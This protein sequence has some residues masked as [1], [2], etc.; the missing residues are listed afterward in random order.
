[1]QGTWIL[2]WGPNWRNDFLSVWVSLWRMSARPPSPIGGLL[3]VWFLWWWTR[4]EKCLVS[5]GEFGLIEV[6][7]SEKPFGDNPIKSLG[8][9]KKEGIGYG[10][11]ELL[12]IVRPWLLLMIPLDLFG[13]WNIEKSHCTV[14]NHCVFRVQILSSK[15]NTKRQS[16]NSHL[17]CAWNFLRDH[18]P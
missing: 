15:E 16:Q 18:S 2:S 11:E 7:E 9:A 4:V 12:G 1:M 10:S 13:L 5:S 14:S 17:E 8:E 6:S 3:G